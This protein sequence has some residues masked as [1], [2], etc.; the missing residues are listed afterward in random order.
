MSQAV[1]QLVQYFPRSG[2][3][4]FGEGSVVT[5]G[6]PA[7]AALSIITTRPS[8][9]TVR[10]YL[11]GEVDLATAGQLRVA[12]L[13]AIGAAKPGAEV[14]VDL[15]RVGFLDAIGV[16]VLLRSRQAAQ[17]AGVAFSV[18]NAQGI[19]QRI[20]EVLGLAGLFEITRPSDA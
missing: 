4:R 11:A 17:D 14:L 3:A 12:L 6:S 1:E 19:V 2:A 10:V 5:Q 9:D 7:G 16:G 13:A 20:I 15:T 8:P 18:Q